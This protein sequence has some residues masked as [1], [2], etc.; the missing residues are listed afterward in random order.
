METASL[1]KPSA[2]LAGLVDVQQV[3]VLRL[4]GLNTTKK[5]QQLFRLVDVG[6]GTINLDV[7]YESQPETVS[8]ASD[9]LGFDSEVVSNVAPR[10]PKRRSKLTSSWVRMKIISPS[11]SSRSI[12]PIS[13]SSLCSIVDLHDSHHG[14]RRRKWRQTTLSHVLQLKNR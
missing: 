6:V 8:P 13:K 4:F 5:R 7:L 1:S 11:P 10:N 3:D 9:A 12:G 14:C 2:S